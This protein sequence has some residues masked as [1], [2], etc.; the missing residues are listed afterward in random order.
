MAIEKG[1]SERRELSIGESVLARLEG[2]YKRAVGLGSRT[3]S[4]YAS[5]DGQCGPFRWD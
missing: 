1:A 4:R 2:L 5:T 3:D